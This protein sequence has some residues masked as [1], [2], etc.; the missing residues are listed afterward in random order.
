MDY[1]KY[2]TSTVDW[3]EENFI[4][5]PYIA[6]FY[7]SISNLFYIFIYYFGLYSIKNIS[8]KY[9][10]KKLFSMLL[11]TGICSFYFHLF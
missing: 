10:G 3:C 2:E 5:T 1:I 11:F 9:Y 6:E 8:C 7:N 4:Y